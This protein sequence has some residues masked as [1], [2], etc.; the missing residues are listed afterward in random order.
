MKETYKN[1][2]SEIN[3]HTDGA[4]LK[5]WREGNNNGDGFEFEATN[6]MKFVASIDELDVYEGEEGFVL[7]GDSHGP[8]AV[9][10]AK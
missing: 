6:E 3:G 2:Q 1:I 8:W 9:R 10:V 7:V 4:A 5:A